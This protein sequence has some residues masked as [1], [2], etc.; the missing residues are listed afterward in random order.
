MLED[1]KRQVLEAN[2]ALPQHNLVTLT[3]ATSAPSTA[4]RAFW[5]SNPPAWITA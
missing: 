3:W 5:L 1:L 2:L 4:T